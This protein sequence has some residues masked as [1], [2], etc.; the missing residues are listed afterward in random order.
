MVEG[1]GQQRLQRIIKQTERVAR[2]FR[3]LDNYERCILAHIAI[4]RP[5][6]P[7]DLATPFH[8]EPALTWRP[9]PDTSA[10]V[11]ARVIGLIEMHTYSGADSRTRASSALDGR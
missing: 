3:N 10:P 1:A 7:H 8:C 11:A 4:I 2:G 6:Q 9:R 5:R